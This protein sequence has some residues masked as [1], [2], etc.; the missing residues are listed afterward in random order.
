MITKQLIILGGG[1]SA[2]EGVEKGLFEKISNSFVFG[3][4][5]AFHY[6][7]PTVVVCVD[8]TFY[9]SQKSYLDLQK[10]I[11]C[12][13]LPKIPIAQN[14]IDLKTS[15]NYNRDCHAGY[16]KSSLCGLFSLSLGIKL[17]DEGEIFLLGY[18]GG[19]NGQLDG[20]KQQITHWYQGKTCISRYTK[21]PFEI[22]HRGIG[23]VSWYNTIDEQR[24]E[25]KKVFK[26]R[27]ETEFEVYKEEQ[28]V[29]IYNV[30]LQSNIE[31]F[32]KITYENFFDKIKKQEASQDELRQ[33]II[34]NLKKSR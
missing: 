16:Y 8:E 18:D 15:K 3:L 32:E 5:Y 31:A 21:E 9:N 13:D 25:G 6:M 1:R 28:K 7:E 2:L 19:S 33:Y 34:Q 17:L 27:A 23:K 14:K 20:N 26:K 4:N 22:R 10:L 30:S 24:I 29:K 11:I 12:Q